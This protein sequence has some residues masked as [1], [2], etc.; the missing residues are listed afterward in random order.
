[1]YGFTKGEGFMRSPIDPSEYST[2]EIDH[3][4][5]RTKE[6]VGF[7]TV[8]LVALGVLFVALAH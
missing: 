2:V 7:A 8:V 1:M 4:W 3:S 6:F 5:E